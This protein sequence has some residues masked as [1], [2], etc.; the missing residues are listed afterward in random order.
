MPLGG[1]WGF[2]GLKNPP[3]TGLYFV[4]LSDSRTY[5]GLAIFLC[6][7]LEFLPRFLRARNAVFSESLSASAN[8][9][10]KFVVAFSSFFKFPA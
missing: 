3:I 4:A 8:T 2:C 7:L 5:A 9:H 6:Q 10:P 1:N